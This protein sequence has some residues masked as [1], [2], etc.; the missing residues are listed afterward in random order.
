MNAT[1]NIVKKVLEGVGNSSYYKEI[2]KIKNRWGLENWDIMSI[3][4]IK[5]EI[6]EQAVAQWKAK[7]ENKTTLTQWYIKKE[8][9]ERVH[10][11]KGDWVGSLLFEVRTGLLKV[12]KRNWE[13]RDDRTCVFCREIETIK[14]VIIECDR[15]RDERER[16]DREMEEILGVRE[17]EN[18]KNEN[19]EGISTILALREEDRIRWKEIIEYSKKYLVKLWSIRLRSIA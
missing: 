19:D 12:K 15:Y 13:N 7:M 18:R 11:I 14:H 1:I 17:W 5:I 16:L 4:K 8:K 10:Y 6:E 9:P 2:Q 3:K